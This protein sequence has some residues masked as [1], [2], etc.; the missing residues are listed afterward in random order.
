[1]S[2]DALDSDGL[3]PNKTRSIDL[4]SSYLIGNEINH[5]N[6]DGDVQEHHDAIKFFFFF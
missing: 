6:G 5:E 4:I 3:N 1:M 2:V